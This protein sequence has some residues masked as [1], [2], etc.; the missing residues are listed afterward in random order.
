MSRKNQETWDFAHEYAGKVWMKSGFFVLVVSIILIVLL[1]NTKEYDHYMLNLF[2]VQ[3]AL[4]MV[5]IP[6]TEKA[7][8]KHFDKEGNRLDK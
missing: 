4:M 5:V 6:M 2:Y 3:M 8:R 1:R 7:L